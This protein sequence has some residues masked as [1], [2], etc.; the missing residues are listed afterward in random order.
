M[1][2]NLK[3]AINESPMSSFQILVVVV[4]IALNMLDG[5]DVLAVAFS[6]PHLASDWHLS[7]K[8]LGTLL[9]ASLFGM[10][11]GGLFIAPFADRIGR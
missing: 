6:A 4:C 11:A 10:A 1:M 5:F 8:Q 7:G 3:S 2:Q 9:S